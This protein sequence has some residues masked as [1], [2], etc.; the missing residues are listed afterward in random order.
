VTVKHG[1]VL[2]VFD[3]AMRSGVMAIILVY[4]DMDL[5]AEYSTRIVALTAGKVLADLPPDQFFS[6][7]GIV[8]AI[9]GRMVGR[10]AK[11]A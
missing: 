11:E 9:V 7:P 8:A 3:A 2:N 1:S 4:H 10:L 5:V 6:D